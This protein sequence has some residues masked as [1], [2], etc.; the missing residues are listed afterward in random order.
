MHVHEV[1]ARSDAV[2]AE[3]ERIASILRDTV[4]RQIYAA[5]LQLQSMAESVD[6]DTRHGIGRVIGDL[7]AAIHDLRCSIF[8]ASD[9]GPVPV[10]VIVPVLRPLLR[11]VLV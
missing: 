1:F 8:P 4:I 11:P 6:D 3:R 2:F 5:G 7:D 10:P 9:P